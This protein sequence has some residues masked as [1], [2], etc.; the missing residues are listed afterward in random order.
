MPIARCS[1]W[2]RHER[3]TVATQSRLANV[4]E[5]FFGRKEGSS[6]SVC[7]GENEAQRSPSVQMHGAVMFKVMMGV[8]AFSAA[9]VHLDGAAVSSGCRPVSSRLRTCRAR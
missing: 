7:G 4:H 5:I 1:R 3:K 2:P 8:T 9:D 6:P